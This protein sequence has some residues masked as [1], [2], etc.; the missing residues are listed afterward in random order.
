MSFLFALCSM[1]EIICSEIRLCSL[2]L[3]PFH[4]CL[5]WGKVLAT[6]FHL[7]PICGMQPMS[8]QWACGLQKISSWLKLILLYCCLACNLLPSGR[9]GDGII[10]SLLLLNNHFAVQY[11]HN[12]LHLSQQSLV[13]LKNWL[14]FENLL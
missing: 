10:K 5:K 9:L 2:T 3:Q 7:Y 12:L 4:V 1:I 8:D 6:E 14:P 11:M 13:S